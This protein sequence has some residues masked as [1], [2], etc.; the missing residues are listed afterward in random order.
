MRVVVYPSDRSGCGHYRL[1][2]PVQVLRAQG[3]DTIIVRPDDPETGIE[4]SDVL[5]FQRPISA[6]LAR[7]IPRLRAQ[8]TAVVADID[9]DLMS[10]DSRNPAWAFHHPKVKP[11]L[12]W[13]WALESCRQATLTTCSTPA[14]AERF[15]APGRSRVLRNYVPSRFLSA[16]GPP[17]RA[18]RGSAEQLIADEATPVLGWTG[19]VAH[20]PDDLRALGNALARLQHPFRVVGPRDRVAGVL[21]INPELVSATGGVPFDDYPQAAASLDVGIAPLADTRFNRAKSWLKPLEYSALGVAWV[22]S[23]LPEYRRLAHLGAGAL[24]TK[25]AAWARELR[26]LLGDERYRSERAEA[27]REVARALTIELHAWRWWEA[28]SEALELERG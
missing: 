25:P 3:H 20:H 23:D 27:G 11:E 10:V 17:Q 1:L 19:S 2:W 16:S 24:A 14:L 13:H 7:L 21:G 18:T 5:V 26:L 4:G 12:T 22:A 8:G 15:G 28:W 6:K 9:D